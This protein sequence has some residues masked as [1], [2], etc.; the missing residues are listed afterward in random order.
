MIS[1]TDFINSIQRIVI[2]K[3]TALQRTQKTPISNYIGLA[4]IIFLIVMLIVVFLPFGRMLLHLLTGTGQ[5]TDADMTVFFVFIPLCLIVLVIHIIQQFKGKGTCLSDENAQVLKNSVLNTLSLSDIK[6][7]VYD[8]NKFFNEEQLMDPPIKG[9]LSYLEQCSYAYRDVNAS[10]YACF[11]SNR[12]Y[13]FSGLLLE[14][15]LQSFYDEPAVFS[16][17]NKDS[18]GG[19]CF[20]EIKDAKEACEVRGENE[21]DIRDLMDDDICERLVNVPNA[22]FRDDVWRITASFWHDKLHIFMD[23]ENELFYK[24]CSNYKNIKA[25]E[26][27]YDNVAAIEQYCRQFE[28]V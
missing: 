5:K 1:K 9:K 21:R 25:Y 18:D 16:V 11:I 17:E 27:F 3:M 10:V 12:D 13:A 8:W 26:T 15:P 4:V 28:D 22:P 7:P 20:D 14:F 19:I 23:V 2:P 6:P 24:I